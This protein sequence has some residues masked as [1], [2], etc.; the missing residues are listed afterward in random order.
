MLIIWYLSIEV[1]IIM[2]NYNTM[3]CIV[4]IFLHIFV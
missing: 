1:E 2:K 4:L 3:Y